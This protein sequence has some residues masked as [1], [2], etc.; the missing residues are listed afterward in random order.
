MTRIE[1]PVKGMHCDGCARTL[2]VA[3]ERLDGVHGAK[4]D[5]A[6]GRAKVSFDPRRVDEQ[7]LRATIEACGYT[8][9]SEQAA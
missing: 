6:G 4:V 7:R 1:I 5:F 3:L 2:S 8:P 9:A